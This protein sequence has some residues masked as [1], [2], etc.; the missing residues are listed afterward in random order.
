MSDC[1]HIKSILVEGWQRGKGTKYD[2]KPHERRGNQQSRNSKKSR[3]LRKRT[4]DNA[5]TKEIK[6]MNKNVFNWWML[7][8]PSYFI[9]GAAPPADDDADA[10]GLLF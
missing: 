1:F 5:L 2:S 6:T 3:R 7:N 9:A 4:V 8:E 10:A